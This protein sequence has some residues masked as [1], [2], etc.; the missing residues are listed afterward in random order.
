M[1]IVLTIVASLLMLVGFLVICRS[2]GEDEYEEEELE[3]DDLPD[4]TKHP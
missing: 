2:S 3:D 1:D 4:Q